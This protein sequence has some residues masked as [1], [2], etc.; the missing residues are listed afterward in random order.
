MMSKHIAVDIC[1]KWSI[2]EGIRWMIHW[3]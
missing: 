2:T 3:L 1:H